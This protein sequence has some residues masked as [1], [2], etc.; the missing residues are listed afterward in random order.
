MGF[1]IS[2]EK[3]QWVESLLAQRLT[4]QSIAETAQIFLC[5]VR[6]IKKSYSYEG[7]LCIEAARKKRMTTVRQDRLFKRQ[8]ERFPLHSARSLAQACSSR[9]DQEHGTVQNSKGVY[10]KP[11]SSENIRTRRMIFATAHHHEKDAFWR[12][13]WYGDEVMVSNRRFGDRPKAFLP[14][15]SPRLNKSCFT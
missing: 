3:N 12:S 7:A 13:L 11:P 15:R 10:F 2:L 1:D 4:M 6:K 14:M 9:N 8:V 5:L